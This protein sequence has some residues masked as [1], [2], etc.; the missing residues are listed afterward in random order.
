MSSLVQSSVVAADL[1]LKL[2]WMV[3]CRAVTLLVLL[4]LQRPLWLSYEMKCE[5]DN[6]EL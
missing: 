3:K 5:V 1:A 2:H 6:T 4:F